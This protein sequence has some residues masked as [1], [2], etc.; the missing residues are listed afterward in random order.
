MA[1][2]IDAGRSEIWLVP[3]GKTGLMVPYRIVLGT[4]W[5]DLIVSA[6]RFAA[7]ATEQRASLD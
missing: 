1:D 6:T 3:V 4:R 7:D 5:G 2:M